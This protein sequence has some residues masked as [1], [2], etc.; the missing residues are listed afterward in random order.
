MPPLLPKKDAECEGCKNK[1]WNS[2]QDDTEE[3]IKNRLVEFDKQT[4][5]LLNH[6]TELGIVKKFV[7]YQGM[8]D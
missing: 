1:E 7:P 2:R 8:A 3:I 5:P 4:A 6:L